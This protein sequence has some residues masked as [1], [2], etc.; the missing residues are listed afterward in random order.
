MNEDSFFL[1]I[2][3]NHFQSHHSEIRHENY[4]LLRNAFVSIIDDSPWKRVG[5]TP[6]YLDLSSRSGASPGSLVLK[7]GIYFLPDPETLFLD[8]DGF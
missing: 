5:F 2:G 7:T 1:K 4:A 6:P 3:F 8:H